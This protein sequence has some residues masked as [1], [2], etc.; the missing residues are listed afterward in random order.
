MRKFS[1]ILMGCILY[2]LLSADSCNSNR[3]E[4]S[5]MHDVELTKEMKDLKTE[6]ESDALTEKSLT[7]F[8]VKAKQKLVD[9]SDFLAI[10][11]TEP[12]D[13]LFKSQARQMILDLFITGK[14]R[15]NDLLVNE[16]D[17]KDILINDFL[18]LK[19]EYRSMNLKC[20]S[21]NISE[22]LHR[23]KEMNYTG[24]LRFYR[25]LEVRTSSDT[26]IIAPARMEV[27]IFVSKVKKPFGKD[28]LQIWNVSLGNMK[29]IF[30]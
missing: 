30:K 24:S 4:S 19:S 7:A 9:F 8:E 27:E 11:T 17:Q 5:E 25:L 26:L 1:Y 16:P 28:T 22:P 21:I 15:I 14:V 29:P 3:P 2:L 12:I 13:E 10:Y 6:F 20:D 23:T 18:D